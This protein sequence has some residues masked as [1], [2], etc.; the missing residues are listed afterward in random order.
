M[1]ICV[2]GAGAIGGYLALHVAR[3]D[4]IEV[5]VVARGAHLDAIRRDGLILQSPRGEKRVQVRA[6][7]R[8]SELG[9]QDCVIVALKSHQ[10]APALAD[11]GS[12][13]GPE[14]TV[15]PPTTGIPY[16]Y[17]HRLAA[18]SRTARSSA[19]IPAARSGPRSRPSA[20]SAASTGSRRRSSRPA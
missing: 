16:W 5:S 9:V 4:G 14:T 1:M 15:V 19:S 13:L 18:G 8:A 10:V 2:F 20:C 3:V 7:D 12:L 17:F 6:T 11:L